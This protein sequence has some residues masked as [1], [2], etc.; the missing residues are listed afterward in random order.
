[1]CVDTDGTRLHCELCVRVCMC[2]CVG[3]LHSP[4]RLHSQRRRASLVPPYSGSGEAKFIKGAGC[5]TTPAAVLP[6]VQ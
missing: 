6:S 4:G 3:H 2:M 5:C 1:M